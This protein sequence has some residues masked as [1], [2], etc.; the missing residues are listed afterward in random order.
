MAVTA[1]GRTRRQFTP[2]SQLIL[3]GSNQKSGD[4]RVAQKHSQKYVTLI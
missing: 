2:E 1:A 3:T 4:E